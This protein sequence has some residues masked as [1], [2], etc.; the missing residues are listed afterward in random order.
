M[1]K[2]LITLAF[3]VLAVNAW[4]DSIIDKLPDANTG[5]IFSMDNG[6]VEPMTS[7]TLIS[8][9]DESVD[10]D[11]G[12]TP[13]EKILGLVSGR[14]VN[15]GDLV[16]FPLS[17]YITIEPFVYV[18]VDRL[19]NFRELGEFDYGLGAKLIEVKF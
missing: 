9:L 6:K 2:A 13:S 4:A 5:V 17:E 19:E 7:I 1:K 3:C 11:L 16:T 15:V 8:F 18:G 10:I 12:Y 14:L